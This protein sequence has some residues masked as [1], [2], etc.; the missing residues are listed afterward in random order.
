MRD[1]FWWY[2]QIPQEGI[3]FV[4]TFR[5]FA[6]F[7]R[8]EELAAHFRWEAQWWENPEDNGDNGKKNAG[9][10]FVDE[11]VLLLVVWIW[12]DIR[13]LFSDCFLKKRDLKRVEKL[14]GGLKKLFVFLPLS[15]WRWSNS[16]KIFFQRGWFN[17]V[18]E[19]LKPK[20]YKVPFQK[21]FFYLGYFGC[22]GWKLRV[23]ST[24]FF[25]HRG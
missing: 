4:Q 1:G 2:L 18:Q 16:M 22:D 10:K 25:N 15:H 12:N 11:I 20:V 21:T 24:D 8:P 13:V 3:P 23:S 7:F 14:G 5:V 19:K 9:G 6:A 17:H